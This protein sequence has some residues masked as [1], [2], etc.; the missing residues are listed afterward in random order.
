MQTVRNDNSSAMPTE[1]AHRERDITWRTKI[2][3]HAPGLH[4]ESMVPTAQVLAIPAPRRA[5]PLVLHSETR[6]LSD[7]IDRLSIRF[8]LHS[9]ATIAAIVSQAHQRFDHS[10]LRD[11]I[12]LLVERDARRQLQHATTQAAP[13]REASAEPSQA[14]VG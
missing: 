3:G 11:F 9:K 10:H 8:P 6:A 2:A 13:T 4:S 7:T 12:P 1:T 5:D 14:G